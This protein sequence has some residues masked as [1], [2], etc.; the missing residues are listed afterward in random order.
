MKIVKLDGKKHNRV[1]FDCKVVALN[2]YLQNIV[3][4]HSKK[5]SARSY[6]LRDEYNS[7][8]IVGFYT[9]SLTTLDISSLSQHLQKSFPLNIYNMRCFG[10]FKF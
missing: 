1:R 8:F 3:N 6:V 4:Q 10:M 9:L 5:D 7:S 2:S